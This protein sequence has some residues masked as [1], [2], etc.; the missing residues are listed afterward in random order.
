M[1]EKLQTEEKI[2]DAPGQPR[3]CSHPIYAR[4]LTGV[5]PAIRTFLHSSTLLLLDMCLFANCSISSAC[6]KVLPKLTFVHSTRIMGSVRDLGKCNA[7]RGNSHDIFAW[8]G[9]QTFEELEVKRSVIIHCVKVTH[10]F[11]INNWGTHFDDRAFHVFC[12]GWIVCRDAFH[13][14]LCL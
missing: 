6:I 1:F 13:V 11:Y 4:T 9:S 14:V 10:P 5:C 12:N 7:S 2:Y 8:N 3:T